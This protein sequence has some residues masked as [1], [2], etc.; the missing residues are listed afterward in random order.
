MKSTLTA[1]LL[2]LPMPVLLSALQPPE[3]SARELF[4]TH[5]ASCH[6]EK[7]DGEGTAELER[8]ARSFVDGGFSFGNTREALRRTIRSGIPGSPMPSWQEAL[9]EEQ[10]ALVT[11]YVIELGP[12]E[13]PKPADTEMIVGDRPAVVRGLLPPIGA[14]AESHPRGLLIGFPSGFSFEYRADDLR[15]LGMRQ[16]RF[17][18][19]TDWVGRGGTALAPLGPVVLLE[20]G[21]TPEA[22]FALRREGRKVNLNSRL[23]ATRIVGGVVWIESELIGTDGEL[24]ARIEECARSELTPFGSGYV[25]TW[26]LESVKP[27]L[28]LELTIAPR[29]GRAP[30]LPELKAWLEGAAPPGLRSNRCSQ[31]ADDL[32]L[33][34]T[35]PLVKEPGSVVVFS[36]G[37]LRLNPET[38]ASE[39]EGR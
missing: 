13:P 2:M 4:I 12:G 32:W 11:D 28:Q 31:H 24:L 3:E 14:E 33:T 21:G 7:G 18:D 8:R 17:V 15:L 25:R 1:L 37:R 34:P 9:T 27:N 39:E 23:R 10:I 6:G 20:Q 19:R 38:P 26:R 35:L 22:T 36:V 16:G 30:E 5:C 29:D